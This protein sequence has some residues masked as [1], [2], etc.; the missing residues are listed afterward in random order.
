MRP[1][2]FLV[3]VLAVAPLSTVNAQGSIP[4]KPGDR[5][6]VTVGLPPHPIVR[7]G[8]FVEVVDENFVL[9]NAR[10]P[11]D[12]IARVEVNRGSHGHG[13]LGALLG[14]LVVGAGGYAWAFGGDGG[15]HGEFEELNKLAGAVVGGLLGLV[16]G[17][18]IGANIR[19][20]EWGN[21]PLD[22]LRVSFAPQRDGRF[23]LGLSVRF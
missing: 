20:Q 21:V 7:Y 23:G 15:Q 17:I 13:G 9:D 16:T 19:T 4:V 11:L 2:T 8:K 3:V 22:Q 18:A 1:V 14:L 5:V 10:V 12:S 6:R